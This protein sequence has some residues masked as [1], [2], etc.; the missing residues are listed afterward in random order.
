MGQALRSDGWSI[1]CFRLWG[2]AEPLQCPTPSHTLS[3][4]PTPAPALRGHRRALSEQ[5]FSTGSELQLLPGAESGRDEGLQD[6]EHTEN[7]RQQQ[8]PRHWCPSTGIARHPQGAARASSLLG[9]SLLSFSG[10]CWP[11]PSS[12]NL[13]GHC[14]FAL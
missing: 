12:L 5:P 1:C 10:K 2:K 9:T 13:F 8:D 11:A 7:F 3:F 6:A 4:V 14:R